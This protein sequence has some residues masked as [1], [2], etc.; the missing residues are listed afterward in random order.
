M[1]IEQSEL[2]EVCR[3]LVAFDTVSTSSNVAAAEYLADL[4]DDAGGEVRLYRDRAL[5]SDK[6]N[7]L[8]WFG[9]ARPQGLILSG[10][11]DVVPFAEQPGW[12]RDPLT[13][14]RDDDRIYGR[15]VADMKG[16]LAQCV[17][18]AR[19]LDAGRLRRPLVF[20]FT[21]DEE[22]GC[23]GAGRLLPHLDRLREELP[24]PTEAVIGEPTSFRVFVAHKGHVRFTIRLEGRGGHA[25]RPDLG[26]NAIAA[27]AEAALALERFADELAGRVDDEGRRLFPD[28]PAVPVNMGTIRGGTAF[29]M[30]AERCELTVGMRPLPDDDPEALLAEIEARMVEAVA[31]SHPD[32][33]LSLHDVLLTP[34]MQ[35]PPEGRA[36]KMLGRLTGNRELV[37]APFATDGGQLQRAGIHSA[38]CGPG[39]LEQAHQPDESLPIA[40]LVKGVTLLGRLI[41]E[42]CS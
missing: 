30:I 25:G 10:H 2:W 42:V 39:E 24:L 4:L 38:I 8:A 29:N 34:A 1:S 14:E 7:L 23:Q 37:G 20:V 41:G 32:A 28:F 3:R 12:T 19:G 6:A 36:V 18:V 16:F 26:S 40:G 33:R 35:S 15:G 31:R 21:C 22:V 9:P 11:M 5:G 13:L 27:A 17:A